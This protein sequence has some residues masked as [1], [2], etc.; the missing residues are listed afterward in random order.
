MTTD[1]PVICTVC[2]SVL[3]RAKQKQ[4]QQ[5]ETLAIVN[6]TEEQ[7]GKARPLSI[8]GSE[9]ENNRATAA[10]NTRDNDFIFSLLFEIKR[11]V[12]DH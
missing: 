1:A 4:Q 10:H 8:G 7:D 12:E 11:T 6:N 9:R 3:W 5:R 2:E